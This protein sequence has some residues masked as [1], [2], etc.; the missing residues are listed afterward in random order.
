MNP[1]IKNKTFLLATIILIG[2]T[3]FYAVF[4]VLAYFF[5]EYIE[6]NLSAS[7]TDIVKGLLTGIGIY[8]LLTYLSPCAKANNCNIKDKN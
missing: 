3:T 4:S 8:V 6:F 2:S 7:I 5:P 1:F